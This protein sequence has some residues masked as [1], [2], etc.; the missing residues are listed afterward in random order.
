M[1]MV[2]PVVLREDQQ[3]G[4]EGLWYVVILSLWIALS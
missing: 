4:S 2:L 3:D 1:A